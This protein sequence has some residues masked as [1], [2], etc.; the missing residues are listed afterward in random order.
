MICKTK[1]HL[2]EFKI[3]K[4]LFQNAASLGLVR[5]LS[6]TPCTKSISAFKKKFKRGL[7]VSSTRR[8]R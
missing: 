1:L 6:N 3:G 7:S 2:T 8:R 5:A 4:A